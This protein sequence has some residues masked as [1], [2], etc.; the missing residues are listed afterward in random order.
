MKPAS[1]H[2]FK[3][4]YFDIEPAASVLPANYGLIQPESIYA[5]DGLVSLENN[6]LLT[7]VEMRTLALGAIGHTV[8]GTSRQLFYSDNTVKV[9][10][11]NIFEDLSVRNLVQAVDRSFETGISVVEQPITTL[12][13]LSDRQ[14]DIVLLLSEGL[15][16]AETATKL[17]ISFHTV[18]EHIEKIFEKYRVS[19]M[20]SVVLLHHMSEQ[21]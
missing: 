5:D 15:T 19:N 6:G 2:N 18:E 21:I 14:T 9:H 12:G 20:A 8:Y 3:P 4:V 13:K 16:R 10:R 11:R 17:G 7:I 1:E